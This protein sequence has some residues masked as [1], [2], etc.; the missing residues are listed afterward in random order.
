VGI[1]IM[2][3]LARLI[4]V[5]RALGMALMPRATAALAVTQARMFGASTALTT[6]HCCLIG[7]LGGNFGPLLLDAVGITNPISRGLGV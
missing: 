4:G 5:P 3:L 6:V 2:T 1:I 7:V